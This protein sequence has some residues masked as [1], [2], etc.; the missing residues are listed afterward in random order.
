MKQ[1]KHAIREQQQT[2]KTKMQP[3][4]Y[5]LGTQK[6]TGFIDAKG[7]ASRTCENMGDSETETKTYLVKLDQRHIQ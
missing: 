2:R 4:G 6:N 1:L 5:T 3:S 7:W